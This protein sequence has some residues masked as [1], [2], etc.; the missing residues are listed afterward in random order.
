MFNFLIKIV[1]NFLL[2]K[3]WKEVKDYWLYRKKVGDI[4]KQVRKD[5]LEIKKE[6]DAAIRAKRMKDYLNS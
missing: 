2:D 6:P 5:I 1:A 4:K 3:V